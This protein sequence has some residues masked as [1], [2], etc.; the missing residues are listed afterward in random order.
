MVNENQDAAAKAAEEAWKVYDR[1]KA[2]LYPRQESPSAKQLELAQMSVDYEQ[3]D[4]A[5]VQEL[6]TEIKEKFGVVMHDIVRLEE[7]TDSMQHLTEHITGKK[8]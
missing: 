1:A 5:K 2:Y 8:F 3:R 6:V 4:L 7:A